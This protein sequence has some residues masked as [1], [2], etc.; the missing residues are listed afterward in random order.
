ML[1]LVNIQS[2]PRVDLFHVLNV[3]QADAL[4]LSVL[5]D[6]LRDT[7][8]YFLALVM[9]KFL[10]P[11]FLLFPFDANCDV[12]SSAILLITFQ[13]WYWLLINVFSLQF[14]L[15]VFQR[16]QLVFRRDQMSVITITSMMVRHLFDYFF[17]YLHVMFCVFQ[18]F[19]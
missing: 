9:L 1:S 19:S 16:F 3:S 14:S 4:V 13:T 8:R 17:P 12:G 6:S 2:C 7:Y 10:F 5:E 15:L 18:I 11:F